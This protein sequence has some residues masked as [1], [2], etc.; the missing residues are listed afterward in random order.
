MFSYLLKFGGDSNIL[1]IFNITR[2]RFRVTTFK[3]AITMA[4]VTA[5]LLVLFPTFLSNYLISN[6]VPVLFSKVLCLSL[7]EKFGYLEFS[8]LNQFVFDAFFKRTADFLC[9]LSQNLNKLHSITWEKVELISFD[10][11]CKKD[12]L[13]FLFLVW[14]FFSLSTT[15]FS[16]CLYIV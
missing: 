10:N 9:V 16:S 3:L 6:Y 7:L 12:A 15:R 1:S 13:S 5:D 2:L 8:F 11:A 14:D 4:V